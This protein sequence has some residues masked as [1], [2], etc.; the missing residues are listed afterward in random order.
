[1]PSRVEA[2]ELPPDLQ[3]FD[4]VSLPGPFKTAQL[5]LTRN[6]SKLSQDR[7]VKIPYGGNRTNIPDHLLAPC[8]VAHKTGSMD[9]MGRL[10]WERPSVTIRTEFVKPEKGRY[11]HPTEH[12]SITH[13][14]AA[15]LQTFPL[16]FLWC[17]AKVHI[18]RQIGNAVPVRL[19]H[20]LGLLI[21]AELLQ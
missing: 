15:L 6:F 20:A 13:A 7:F 3:V 2:T 10:R 11:L 21:A 5:H 14:E 9:V 8:W 1:L 4:H 18:A 12:R 17:G 19:A 16:D